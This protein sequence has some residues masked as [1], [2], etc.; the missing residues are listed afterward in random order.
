MNVKLQ[1]IS[2]G[3]A[4][5]TLI[6]SCGKEK[7]ADASNDPAPPPPPP[8]VSTTRCDNSDRPKVSAQYV[9]IGKLSQARYGISVATVGNKIF[10]A[11]GLTQDG[12]YVSSRV[13]I[14][15]IGTRSWSKTELSVPRSNMATVVAGSKVFFAGGQ[16]FNQVSLTTYSAVDIY[17]VVTKS[18]TVARLSEA[19]TNVA[20]AA[21]GNKV[22]FAGGQKGLSTTS[23]AVDV[24]D[25]DTGTWSTTRLSE[26]RCHISAV[27]VNNKIYFGGGVKPKNTSG[28]EPS[29]RIDIYDNATS[30][31]STDLLKQPMGNVTSVAVGDQVYW[32]ADCSVEIKNI[33]TGNSTQAFLYRPGSW[34]NDQGQ[35]AVIRNNKIIFFRHD[36]NKSNLFDIYDIATNTWSIGE[37]S[38]VIIG[39]SIVSVG[40][41]IYLAGGR[42]N[43]VFL[44]DVVSR[45]EF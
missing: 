29:N 44:L 22:F 43:D 34:I 19:R 38:E 32:A 2:C 20:A 23:S 16:L 31:W 15:D 40:N 21:V 3:V 33:Q 12:S 37:A 24:Y 13:D 7:G 39:A 26:D 45:L 4:L 9:P 5:L 25:L 41:T 18:W 8:P 35:Q 42:I 14:Y 17:D 10:Y 36:A 30:T 11:G 27:T 1:C 6:L 28:L